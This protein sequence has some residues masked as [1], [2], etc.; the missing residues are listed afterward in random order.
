MPALETGAP[1]PHGREAPSP[2][3]PDPWHGD[4]LAAR[5]VRFAAILVGPIAFGLAIGLQSWLLFAVVTGILAFTVDPG[6]PALPR[7]GWL[8]GAGLVVLVGSGIGTLAAGHQGLVI[9]SFAAVGVIYALVESLHQTYAVGARFLCLTVAVGALYL[10]LAPVDVLVVAAAVLYAWLVSITWDVLVGG[11]R[12]STAPLL[13]GMSTLLRVTARE[14]RSFA[15]AVAIAVPLAYLTST[16]LGLHRP[17]WTLIVTVIVLRAD[18]MSSG[19]LMRDMLGGTLLGIG[20]ALAYGLAFPQHWMLLA[21]MLLAAL[22]RWP[23]QQL[24]GAL[25]MA[26][27]T[28]FVILLIELISGSV[29]GAT[30]DI[31]ARAVDVAVGCGFAVVA[32]LLDWLFRWLFARIEPAPGPKA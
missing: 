5:S 19:R 27:L 21:G 10:P 32:L 30:Q 11:P 22:V 13:A 20:A 16:A 3:A 7:L 12:P 9:A 23:A 17:Y 15:A 26:A 25:G 31:E 29:G 28:A 4:G 18:M 1:E 8:A 6:G 14:R 24:H 2:T